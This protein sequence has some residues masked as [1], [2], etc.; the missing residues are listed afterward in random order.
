MAAFAAA[1]QGSVMS[2]PQ[3][4]RMKGIKMLPQAA[5]RLRADY[6]HNFRAQW[7]HN[8]RVLEAGASSQTAEALDAAPPLPPEP[9]FQCDLDDQAL[10]VVIHVRRGD[11]TASSQ[12]GDKDRL[13]NIT[14]ACMRMCACVCAY[15]CA[16]ARVRNASSS[17]AA[18]CLFCRRHPPV[19]PDKLL[20]PLAGC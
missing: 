12:T 1:G 7:N 10:N 8:R 9:N 6:W 4:E 19:R 17:M 18:R 2:R 20:G 11:I 16:C 5:R 14:G 13:E 3:N 15:V